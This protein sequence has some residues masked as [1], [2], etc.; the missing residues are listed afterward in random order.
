MWD[1]RAASD[2]QALTT[3]LTIS[4]DGAL[5]ADSVLNFKSLHEIEDGWDYGYVQVSTDGGASWTNL[6]GNITTTSDPNA[7]EPGQRNHGQ[8]WGTGPTRRLTWPRTRGRP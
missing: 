6:A 8:A 7:P 3:N 2:G 1:S 5:P 4:L